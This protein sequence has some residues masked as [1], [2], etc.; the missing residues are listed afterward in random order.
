[1]LFN[2]TRAQPINRDI[3]LYVNEPIIINSLIFHNDVRG[4][5]LL[6]TSMMMI[7]VNMI[8]ELSIQECNC[9][10]CNLKSL[11]NHYIMLS[12]MYQ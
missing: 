11:S 9:I 10:S 4:I 2:L 6:I 7:I 8:I 5:F 1:M 12:I 3:N